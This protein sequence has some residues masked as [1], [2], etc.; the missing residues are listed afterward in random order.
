MTWTATLKDKQK[1]EVSW[2]WVFVFFD[3]QKTIVKPYTTASDDDAVIAAILRS[4]IAGFDRVNTPVG[5]YKIGDQIDLTPPAQPIP[6]PEPAPTPENSARD[7]FD[8]AHF[9][10]LRLEG[11]KNGVSSSAL[12]QA[13]T[14]AQKA[15]QAAWSDS[16]I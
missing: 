11:Y 7:A 5:T 1:G 12:D 10:L 14:D 3:G 2:A 13:I 8:Y 4:E 15:K 9:N 6:P 16:F